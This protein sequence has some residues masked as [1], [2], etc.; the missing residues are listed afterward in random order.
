M[1]FQ[2]NKNDTRTNIREM[3]VKRRP[4]TLQGVFCMF[5]WAERNMNCYFFKKFRA[6]QQTAIRRYN[7]HKDVQS[8]MILAG[9]I[10]FRAI[11]SHFLLYYIFIYDDNLFCL[12]IFLVFIIKFPYF[13]IVPMHCNI[14]LNCTCISI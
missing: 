8:N 2:K 12:H 10:I 7:Q 4:S 14:Y 3:Q 13:C 11:S 6:M 9:E 1:S 5:K